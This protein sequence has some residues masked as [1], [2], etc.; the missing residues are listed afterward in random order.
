MRTI[1]IHAGPIDVRLDSASGRVCL[2][3]HSPDGDLRMFRLMP[4]E[5]AQAF[6]AH[7]GAQLQKASDS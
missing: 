1:E 7:L 3:F 4:L 5:E 2:V 6:H